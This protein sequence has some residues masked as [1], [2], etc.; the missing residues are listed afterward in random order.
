M[1]IL[2]DGMQMIQDHVFS[3]SAAKHGKWIPM[4]IIS[5][6]KSPRIHLGTI[7]NIVNS[8]VKKARPSFT[9]DDIINESKL[10][11]IDIDKM[12]NRTENR[13]DDYGHRRSI[14]DLLGGHGLHLASRKEKSSTGEKK[15]YICN[16]IITESYFD[17]INTMVPND[18]SPVDISGAKNTI[19]V[20]IHNQKSNGIR[21]SEFNSNPA[22][23]RFRLTER[24][25]YTKGKCHIRRFNLQEWCPRKQEWC[26]VLSPGH[27]CIYFTSQND[28][29]VPDDCLFIDDHFLQRIRNRPKAIIVL[30]TKHDIVYYDACDTETIG[31]TCINIIKIRQRDNYY[32][33]DV[34]K[35]IEPKYLLSHVGDDNKLRE[36]VQKQ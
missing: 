31:R 36:I 32:A 28:L 12:F 23:S 5:D 29:P 18:F 4:P 8:L 6:K 2:N 21:I 26:N 17:T 9:I 30:R 33:F 13:K 20:S 27:W 11:G 16:N 14:G 3:G 19:S 10:L 34:V 24:E 15:Y 25:P 22:F 1:K 35:P 7:A